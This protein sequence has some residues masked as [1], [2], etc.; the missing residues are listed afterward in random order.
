AVVK[1]AFARGAVPP[2]VTSFE[3]VPGKGVVARTGAGAVLVGSPA[4]LASRGIDLSSAAARIQ[5]LE[6]VGR[7]VI[8]GEQAQQAT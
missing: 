6:G 8:V 3:A 4:F 1:A 2:D 7:T 5:D